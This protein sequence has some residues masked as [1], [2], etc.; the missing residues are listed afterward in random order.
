MIGNLYFVGTVEASSHLLDTGDGLILIDTGYKETADAIIESMGILGFDPKDIKV[1]LFSHGHCDHTDGTSKILSLAPLAKTYMSFY[2]LKYIKGFVPDFD[3]KD[4]DVIRLGNT[5]V[6]CLFTPGHTEGSVSFFFDVTENGTVYRA[7]MFGGSGTNQL[8]KDFMD[9]QSVSYLLRGQFFD[10]VERLLSE[11]VD[12][13]IGNHTWQNHTKEKYQKMSCAK[14]NPFIDP[15][16]WGAYLRSLERKLHAIIQSESRQC[17]VTYAHRGASEYCPENTFLSFYTGLYMGANGIETDVRKTK[18]GVL[19]LFHD[20]TLERVV[21]KEGA[22]EDYTYDELQDFLVKKGE[23]SDWIP[24]LEDFLSH[25][26][27]RNITFAIELKAPDV[28][29]TVA[30][31]ILR[32]G[33]EKKTFVTSFNL[34]YIKNIK[35]YAPCLRIGYLAKTVDQTVINELISIGADEICPRGTDVTPDK[36]AAWHRLGFN[37][38]AW[39]I[40]DEQIMRAVYDAG[41]DGMTVNFPDRLI[42]YILQRGTKDA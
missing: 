20:S 35:K 6:L 7:A 22:I 34:E 10:S 27:H 15:D 25:F 28:E 16:E 38:R 21:G 41:A 29:E 19:V 39:G 26:A 36:V 5:E 40:S 18:D 8:K 23:L 32:Y 33:V 24:T 9:R 17:F 4:G 2:D 13:M 12:V 31:M 14:V 30:D 42:S 3:I 37:V 11:H 1:I